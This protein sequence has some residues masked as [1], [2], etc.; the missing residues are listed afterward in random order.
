MVL[1]YKLYIVNLTILI[2]L[3]TFAS[4]QFKDQLLKEVAK[5]NLFL[6]KKKIRKNYDLACSTKNAD[7]DDLLRLSYKKKSYILE[8]LKGNI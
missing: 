1:K 3:Q 8:K 2:N 5:D 6:V 7:G 4:S